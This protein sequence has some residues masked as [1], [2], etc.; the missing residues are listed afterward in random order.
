MRPLYIIYIGKLSYC[1]E[2]EVGR[3][4]AIS[5]DDTRVLSI[6]FGHGFP[7][8]YDYNEIRLWLS[9]LPILPA[10]RTRSNFI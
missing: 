1:N 7:E 10:P 4:E 6:F 9:I 2:Y 3:G 8:N 5:I